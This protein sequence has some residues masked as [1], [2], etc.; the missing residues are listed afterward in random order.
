MNNIGVYITENQ[1]RTVIREELETVLLEEGMS[2]YAKKVFKNSIGIAMMLAALKPT[3]IAEAT[4]PNLGADSEQ[5]QDI[6]KDLGINNFNALANDPYTPEDKKELQAAY[7]KMRPFQDRLQKI[8]Q[9]KQA[10]EQQFQETEDKQ[11]A[12]AIKEKYTKLNDLQ[13]KTSQA[14]TTITAGLGPIAEKVLEQGDL[15]GIVIE[16]AIENGGDLSQVDT[17]K[18]ALD[19]VQKI[20]S[21]DKKAQSQVLN[22]INDT[23][24]TDLVKFAGSVAR[25]AGY[26]GVPIS[27]QAAFQIA[28]SYADLNDLGLP[29]N[30]TTIDVVRTLANNKDKLLGKHSDFQTT[31]KYNLDGQLMVQLN[32]AMKE[33][34][35]GYLD[36]QELEDAENTALKMYGDGFYTATE[37]PAPVKE[38]KINKLRQRINELRGVYV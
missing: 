8:I 38:N 19:M 29:Q 11:E 3:E 9:A 25:S 34:P 24:N 1:I 7:Q 35:D 6:F 17:Q 31:K 26:G 20:A 21:G 2:D 18:V 28:A 33:N 23:V 4:I 27:P 13:Q 5:A 30:P 14:L 12:A 16:N 15:T 22:S 37:Q 36:R 10:L 32:V